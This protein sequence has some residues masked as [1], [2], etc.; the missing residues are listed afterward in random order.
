MILQLL[1]PERLTE[2]VDIGANP[3]DGDPPYKPLL[4]AG[5]C[6]VTGFDPQFRQVTYDGD[7][8]RYFPY[9]VGDGRRHTLSVC[10]APGMTS[11]LEPDP[12][13]LAMFD[14]LRPLADV[15]KLVEMSTHRLDDLTEI[16]HMD[17]LKID[18]QGSELSV[19]CNGAERLARAVCVQT[20]VSFVPLYRNQP[21]IGDVDCELRRQGFIPHCCVQ[22]VKRPIGHTVVNGDPSLGLNQLVEADMVYIRLEGLDHEQWKH[23]ALIAH[24]CYRSYDLAAY[25]IEKMEGLGLAPRDAS[26][27]YLARAA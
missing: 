24:H 14:F 5:L 7:R 11:L 9:A 3:I 23:L 20:E 1:A 12:D 21:T 6:R 8:E 27:S 2:V 16:Q 17:F 13:Q 25:C 22:V 10:R 15:T 19:F 26:Q 4:D 18:I